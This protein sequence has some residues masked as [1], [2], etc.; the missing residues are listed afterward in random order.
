M[1]NANITTAMY[2][3][4]QVPPAANNAVPSRGMMQHVGLSNSV[5]GG[6]FALHASLAQPQLH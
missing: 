1:N 4:E 5:F 3:V 6:V 2:I